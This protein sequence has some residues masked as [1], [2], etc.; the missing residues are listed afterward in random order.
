MS[1]IKLINEKKTILE[2]FNKAGYLFCHAYAKPLLR[3][4]HLTPGKTISL[5]SL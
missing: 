5:L 1:D 2:S 4:L 3:S